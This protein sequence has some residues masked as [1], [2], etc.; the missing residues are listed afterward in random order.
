MIFYAERL[1]TRWWRIWGEDQVKLYIWVGRGGK[2]WNNLKK[3][4]KVTLVVMYLGSGSTAVTVWKFISIPSNMCFIMFSSFYMKNISVCNV[5]FR[6]FGMS[7]WDCY[8]CSIHLVFHLRKQKSEK[9]DYLSSWKKSDFVE[10]FH[11][12]RR[13]ILQTQT[14]SF[15]FAFLIFAKENINQENMLL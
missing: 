14:S 1:L 11:F 3:G 5:L 12:L 9:C 7:S 4:K 13:N 10:L 6:K 2:P 8:K 15:K